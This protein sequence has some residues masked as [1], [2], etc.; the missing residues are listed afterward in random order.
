MTTPSDWRPAD[1]AMLDEIAR[2]PNIYS[3]V[4]Q[5]WSVD[6]RVAIVNIES[7]SLEYR[8]DASYCFRENG[9]L[10]RLA[11][12]SSGMTNI[13]DEA[14]YFD[15]SGR[16]VATSSK[17]ALLYPTPGATVSPDLKASKPDVFL[18][19]E[20]LPFFGLLASP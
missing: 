8:E 14:R 2:D 16:V 9:T 3:E 6:G 10:A 13:D 15:P 18:R 4:A 17:L 1:A 5:V 7:R 11:S 20:T 19:V 12:T